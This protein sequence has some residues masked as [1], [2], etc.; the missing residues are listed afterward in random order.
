MRFRHLPHWQPAILNLS[1]EGI[2]T[3]ANFML[4]EHERSE[5]DSLHLEARRDDLERTGSAHLVGDL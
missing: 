1:C 3:G 4:N 5:S 2:L